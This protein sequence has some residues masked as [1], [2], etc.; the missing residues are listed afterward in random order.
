MINGGHNM[1]DI[2]TELDDMEIS[3]E[4]QEENSKKYLTFLAD[5]L[6]FGV[7]VDYVTEIITN[8]SITLL[9][10]LPDYLKGIINLRGQIIPILDIRLRMNKLE[11]TTNE[12]SCVIVLNID[13]IYI[14]ILVD[15]VSQ[16]T[17][18]NEDKISPP[19]ANNKQE[20]INGIL[21]LPDGTVLLLLDCNLLVN[22]E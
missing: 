21:S 20:L 5:G 18:I 6:I 3:N 9:P 8:H 7:K 22:N 2:T 1:S 11:N 13:S 14:G 4:L 12:T 17:D 10:M 19:P 16:V 15:M